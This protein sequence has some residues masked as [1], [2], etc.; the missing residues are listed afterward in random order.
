MNLISLLVPS[1]HRPGQLVD[2]WHSAIETAVDAD[3]VELIVR[4]DEDDHSYDE[5]R[6]RGTRGQVRWLQGPRTILSTMWN[7]AY[8][9]ARGDILM[10]CADDIRFRTDTWD[11]YVITTFEKIPDKIAFVYGRDG[12]HDQALGTHGFIH[13]KWCETVGC[14]VPPHFSSDFNDTWLNEVAERLGRRIYIP[15]ILTEHMHPAWGKGQL[16]QTYIDQLEQD[17][18][19]ENTARWHATADQRLEWVQLLSKEID[20]QR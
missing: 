4:L 2:M 9:L 15:E 20:D 3:E 5:L 13:R 6:R 1:R 17:H 7:E 16:D 14:F 8:E 11:A 10:H 12:G 18:L 19:D